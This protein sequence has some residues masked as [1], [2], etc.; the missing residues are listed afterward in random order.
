MKNIL[1]LTELELKERWKNYFFEK[2]NTQNI[3]FF[4]LKKRL[5]S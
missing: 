2:A 1:S 5:T 3:I 4:S